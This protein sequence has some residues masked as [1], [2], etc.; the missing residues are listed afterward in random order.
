[1]AVS[2]PWLE[3]PR[4]RPTSVGLN[5]RCPVIHIAETMRRLEEDFGFPLRA[6]HIPICGEEGERVPDDEGWFRY[7]ESMRG[8]QTEMGFNAQERK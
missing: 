8:A 6:Y 4:L 5:C 7:S 3:W 1:M 2:F